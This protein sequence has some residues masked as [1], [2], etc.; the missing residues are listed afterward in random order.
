[1]VVIN[2]GRCDVPFISVSIASQGGHQAQTAVNDAL[3]TAAYSIHAML[4]LNVTSLERMK[5]LCELR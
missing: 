2:M 1:M 4:P 5:H 3:I